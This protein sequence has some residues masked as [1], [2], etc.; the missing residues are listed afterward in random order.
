MSAGLRT[1]RRRVGLGLAAAMLCAASTA[2]IALALSPAASAAPAPTTVGAQLSVSGVTTQGDLLGGTTVGI[3]P[4]DSVDFTASL[5][6]T[7]GL[8][9]IP[10]L[11]PMVRQLVRLLLNSQ[12][13]VEMTVSPD[14]PGG[15]RTVALGGPT[16]GRCAGLPDLPV[17]FPKAGT[18]TFT[19]TIRYLLPGLLGGCTATSLN[20]A[21]LNLLKG[22]GVAVNLANQWSGQVVVAASP[23][24]AGLSL[25]L[26]QLGL[27]PSI[28]IVGN[29]VKVTVPGIGVPT[30]PVTLPTVPSGGPS[31]GDCGTCTGE[32]S[33][34]SSSTAPAPDTNRL[35]LLGEGLHEP[36]ITNEVTPSPTPSSTSATAKNPTPGRNLAENRPPAAQM[37]LVL[38]VIALVVL[39][40][41]T[42]AY[43]RLVLMRRNI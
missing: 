21:D 29:V 32:P 17:G 18:Y 25:Q 38:G 42:A 7:A 31:T 10:T 35:I 1:R 9:N 11:G 6:P 2:A 40:L 22:I 24:P 12:F 30:V 14:F 37:P 4:G 34:G 36:S 3:H 8:D 41:V 33:S 5:L 27:N 16:T 19:W 26:P 23:P 15:A 28:P 20:N 39:T 13:R 43:A